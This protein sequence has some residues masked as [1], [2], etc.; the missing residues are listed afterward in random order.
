MSATSKVTE[1]T[2]ALAYVN[3]RV[4]CETLGHGEAVYLV[5]EGDA[6]M[7]QVGS[8]QSVFVERSTTLT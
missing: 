4:R 2:G 8:P 1:E 3:F 6:K 7:Q 5:K